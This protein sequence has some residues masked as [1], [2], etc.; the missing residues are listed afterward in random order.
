MIEL[1]TGIAFLMSSLYG[2]G[3]IHT[4]VYTVPADITP[5]DEIVTEVTNSSFIDPK[6]VEAYLRK[7]YIDNPILVDIARCESTFRQFHKDGTLVH[8]RVDNADV[9][10]MQINLRY[11]GD[12]ANKMGIDLKTVKGNVEYGQYLYDK[13]GTK[14]WSASEK[15]WSKTSAELARK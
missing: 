15:C 11:H 2:A 4:Q 12:T 5:E 10:V 14:P 8:G 13:F 7:E 6:E 9:G 1:T 3:N